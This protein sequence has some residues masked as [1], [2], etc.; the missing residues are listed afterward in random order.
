MIQPTTSVMM[1]LDYNYD[2][3]Y[4][5][6]NNEYTVSSIT[7]VTGENLSHNKPSAVIFTRKTPGPSP[8]SL[9]CAFMLPSSAAPT[10]P[11]SVESARHRQ[12]Q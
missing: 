11:L 10:D 2:T 3:Q 4:D 8:T 9:A 7:V 6:N 1:S 12:Q 5:F